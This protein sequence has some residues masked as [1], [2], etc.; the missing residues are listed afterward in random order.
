MC[1]SGRRGALTCL[2]LGVAAVSFVP[3]LNRWPRAPFRCLRRLR[4]R[5]LASQMRRPA[6]SRTR[7]RWPPL[8]PDSTASAMRAFSAA[9]PPAIS[10]AVAGWRPYSEGS[11]RSS[12]FS[13]RFPFR[14][15]PFPKERAAGPGRRRILVPFDALHDHHALEPHL[16]RRREHLFGVGQVAQAKQ[17]VGGTRQVVDLLD[18]AQA[19]PQRDLC[20]QLAQREHLRERIETGA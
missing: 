7:S 15:S 19:R 4:L 20:P 17:A 10:S 1:A 18:C 14:V 16:A 2:S 9:S 11:M 5:A 3:R 8:S 6:F 13:L 12:R